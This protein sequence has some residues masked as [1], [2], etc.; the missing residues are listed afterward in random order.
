MPKE[1]G[2]ERRSFF[3]LRFA[4]SRAK[5]S[6]FLRGF[7]GDDVAKLI[8]EPLKLHGVFDYS[9][10]SEPKNLHPRYFFF[11]DPLA[12]AVFFTH[13]QKHTHRRAQE[14]QFSLKTCRLY[15]TQAHFMVIRCVV[16]IVDDDQK[17]I[18]PPPKRTS[19]GRSASRRGW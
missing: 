13:T 7:K 6:F 8:K 11:F 19:I 5:R 1:G 15:R 2:V 17:R 16:L 4:F 14:T 9:K 18:S 10:C 3:C 12:H